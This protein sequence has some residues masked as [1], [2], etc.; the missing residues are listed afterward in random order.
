MAASW[1]PHTRN[2]KG[3]WDM[4]TS[5]SDDWT[6]LTNT[7]WKLLEHFVRHI[8]QSDLK[9]KPTRTKKPQASDVLKCQLT[10]ELNRL[11]RK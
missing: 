5:S 4:Q 9:T 1:N 10:A 8:A 7:K 11:V 2:E 6:A 3:Q